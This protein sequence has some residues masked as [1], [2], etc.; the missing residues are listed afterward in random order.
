MKKKKR[1]KK[2]WLDYKKSVN[3]D[4]KKT[5]ENKLIETYIPFVKKIANKLFFQL[6]KNIPMDD[7]F[8]Y[9]IDGLYHTIRRYDIEKDILFESYSYLRIK[10]SMI[11][12]VRK[13][14]PI[15]RSVRILNGK[16]KNIK[17][18]KYL[19]N[20]YT[21]DSE[22]VGELDVDISDFYKNYKKYKPYQVMSL[23]GLTDVFDNFHEDYNINL[24][25]KENLC[26]DDN[27]LRKEFFNKLIGTNFSKIEQKIIYMYY[28][29]GMTMDNISKKLNMSESRISQL[30]QKSLKKMKDKIERN[31]NYF[32]EFLQSD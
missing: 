3:E 17:D 2:L 18:K 15:P 26:P 22:I 7:L 27:I 29:L 12:G 11:D 4:D 5:Y 31:P 1:Y 23:D 30:H 9:G 20:G 10:G 14:D 32:N 13:E 6:H 28:Y 25:D 16:Y 24:E 21:V 8:S 19:E